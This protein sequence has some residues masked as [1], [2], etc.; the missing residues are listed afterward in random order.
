MSRAQFKQF[1]STRRRQLGLGVVILFLILMITGLLQQAISSSNWAQ[2]A[3]KVQL[4]LERVE[5]LTIRLVADVRAFAVTGD[6]ALLDEQAVLRIRIRKLIRDIERANLEDGLQ[7]DRVRQ[8]TTV[9]EDRLAVSDQMID[10]Q[11][12][13]QNAQ[14]SRLMLKHDLPSLRAVHAATAVML[15][16]GQSQLYLRLAAFQ[17]TCYAL[18]VI[19]FIG[20]TIFIIL[21]LRSKTELRRRLLSEM[22]VSRELMASQELLRLVVEH[23]PNGVAVFDRQMRYLMASNRWIESFNLDRDKLIGRCQYEVFP[24]LA[25]SWKD[26]YRRC[27]VGGVER[28]DGEKFIQQDGTVQWLRWEVRPWRDAKGGI[29]GI[30]IFVEDVTAAKIAESEL[31]ESEAHFRALANSVPQIVWTCG[32]DGMPEYF[33]ERW[34]EIFGIERGSTQQHGWEQMVF[35][36]DRPV[37]LPQWR[38]C[39]AKGAPFQ[40]ECRLRGH[41]DEDPRWYLVRAVVVPGVDGGRLRWFGTCTDIQEQK[42]SEEK[43][44]ESETLMRRVIEGVV[45]GVIT[46]AQ[47]GSILSW[48]SGAERIFCYRANE[49]IGQCITK[50]I[51]SSEAKGFGD[52]LNINPDVF[53]VKGSAGLTRE[54]EAR[55]RDGETVAI[56]VS[57]SAIQIN[58]KTI[59]VAVIRDLTDRKAAE[60]ERIAREAAESANQAKSVFLANMSHEIRTPMNGIIGLTELSLETQLTKQQREYMM[61]VQS[62]AVSLLSIINDILDFSKIEAGKLDLD[63]SPFDLYKVVGAILKTISPKVKTND[64]ELIC[65]ISQ[66]VPTGLIG[67]PCR[68]GQVLTNL[69]GNA[70]KFTSVGTVE[71]DISRTLLADSPAIRFVVRDT[72]I[73]IA[74]DR[75]SD[76][77]DPFVQGDRTTTRNFGGTGLGL[78]ISKK[79]VKLMGGEISVA[80]DIGTGSEFCVMLPLQEAPSEFCRHHI[81]LAGRRVLIVENN[82]NAAQVIAE[83][84]AAWGADVKVMLAD[85]KWQD[86]VPSETCDLLLVSATCLRSIAQV[87]Q[88]LLPNPRVKTIA[89]VSFAERDE[90]LRQCEEFGIVHWLNKPVIASELAGVLRLAC[91]EGCKEQANEQIVN[92]HANDRSLRVLLADD[93]RINQIIAKDFLCRW[94]HQVTIANDG[95]E[96]LQLIAKDTFD[97]VLLDLCMPKQDGFSVIRKIRADEVDCARRLPVIALTAQAMAGD[98]QRCIDAGFDDYLSK[99]F[100]P[101]S[102]RRKILEL[103]HSR[104][105]QAWTELEP[106]VVSKAAVNDGQIFDLQLAMA[107]CGGDLEFLREVLLLHQQT[108]KE[109]L[110]LMRQALS[111][112]NHQELA[113]QAHKLRGGA[114]FFGARR[115]TDLTQTI[116]QLAQK[117]DFEA[118][119]TTLAHL[120][121]TYE[122]FDRMTASVL[123][124]DTTDYM[125]KIASNVATILQV[126]RAGSAPFDA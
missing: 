72:G 117:T 89:M 120:E 91:H 45:D 14:V 66:D 5:K 36:D 87:N 76:I 99:P 63:V 58:Q 80:S 27:L 62:S 113:Q 75:L 48:N 42:A 101:Q 7:S 35:V 3:C 29:G 8:L 123:C 18:A 49:V 26:V 24:D 93:N 40:A 107:S 28:S 110:S 102:L 16:E 33:N 17:R 81:D 52:Y 100:E 32:P 68:L 47:D 88:R 60:K 98:S 43:L 92:K 70:V 106:V 104:E 105:V 23:G 108:A 69:L 116:E 2:R 37:V 85:T 53:S 64:I 82:A 25:E 34:F 50:M 96:A 67:D 20:A 30:T 97:L 46:I 12:K 61:G 125:V 115:V 111:H 121:A 15:Q 83:L 13:H 79:L 54:V 74:Q 126:D 59:F 51:P 1:V 44:V 118:V 90:Q 65:R 4:L 19:T 38:R 11:K 95:D 73:G 55:R 39:L 41:E 22:R 86:A 71:L 119:T 84:M 124:R 109:S 57:V 77:F 122:E 6:P 94:G 21:L 103:M 10:L 112:K 78:S 9:I 114:S 56:E 31:R